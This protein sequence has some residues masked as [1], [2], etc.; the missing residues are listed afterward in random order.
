MSSRTIREGSIRVRIFTNR[1]NVKG[2]VYTRHELRWT[3]HHGRRRRLKRSSQGAAVKEARRIAE[4]LA[5]GHHQAELS[6]AD[7]AS[8]RAAIK[9]LQ[10]IG[11]SLEL[12]AAEYVDAIRMCPDATLAELASFYVKHRPRAVIQMTVTDA[13]KRFLDVKTLQGVGK[14]TKATLK[15][16]L[17]R[18]ARDHQ[19]SIIDVTSPAIQRWVLDLKAA[20]RTRNNYLAAV[21]SLF[22]SA[23]LD[24]HPDARSIARL[25]PIEA[26]RGK[27]AIW[28]P[29][30]FAS[31][32]EL[33]RI[34]FSI[35]SKRTKRNEPRSH[36]HLLPALVLGGFGKL[37]TAEIMRLQW[38]DIRL[39]DSQVLLEAGQAK[40]K[41]RRIAPLPACAVAW[42]RLCTGRAGM[43]WP[44]G[45]DKYHTDMRALALRAKLTWRDNALRKS[46]NTYSALLDAD[47]KRV[48]AEAGNSQSML[49]N[50]YLAFEGVSK[51]DAETWFAIL[52]KRKEEKILP[53][54]F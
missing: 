46:A 41:R 11:K 30:E 31:L 7:L 52:P 2:K 23:E 45:P 32:L 20:A 37:R 29:E 14:R 3:D 36:I 5:R 43:V 39:Q 15:S 51:A 35:Q 17:E 42:L 34:P 47:T 24:N 16:Q 54:G 26:S 6:L 12:V 49:E 18:F 19:C 33:A 27:V 9:T 48:A 8:F 53:V 40:T 13:V 38:E 44:H 25:Q 1:T 10:P 4:D 50:Y 22:A 21:Q 28:K